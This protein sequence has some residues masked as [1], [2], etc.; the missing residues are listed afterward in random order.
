[1]IAYAFKTWQLNKNYPAINESGGNLKESR[2]KEVGSAWAVMRRQENYY[3][4]RRVIG[5]GVKG[6]GHRRRRGKTKRR[7]MN[8][9]TEDIREKGLSGEEVYD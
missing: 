6:E 1:M 4:G 5:L 9:V 8:I 2:G 3:A 7:W